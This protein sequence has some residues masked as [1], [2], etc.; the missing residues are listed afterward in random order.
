[1]LRNE[2]T[3]SDMEMEKGEASGLG[4]RVKVTLKKKMDSQLMVWIS[5]ADWSKMA[6][7]QIRGKS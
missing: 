6:E 5:P 3:N 1:M 2:D 7:K 4:V